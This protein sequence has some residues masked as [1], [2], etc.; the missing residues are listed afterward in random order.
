MHPGS[1][2]L[3]WCPQKWNETCS[4]IHQRTKLP[5]APGDNIIIIIIIIIITIIIILFFSIPS[6]LNMWGHGFEHS[7]SDCKCPFDLILE[8]VPSTAEENHR[9]SKPWY[10]FSTGLR[11]L[12]N[13]EIFCV[14]LLVNC[15][16]VVEVW[17][18]Y[19]SIRNNWK[20]SKTNCDWVNDSRH[21]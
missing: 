14:L 5:H 21:C 16:F 1:R 2:V 13:K 3:W 12:L 6:F 10:Q 11:E 8:N 17:W 20:P 7:P 19:H 18:V 15:I 9:N 4:I